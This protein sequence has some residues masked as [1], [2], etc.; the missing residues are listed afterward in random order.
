MGGLTELE[1]FLATG[2]P[3]PTPIWKD[4]DITTTGGLW[5]SST[6]T[7]LAVT[8]M[9]EP[10]VVNHTKRPLLCN[11]DLVGESTFDGSTPCLTSAT[12]QSRRSCLVEKGRD[13]FTGF[14]PTR[15]LRWDTQLRPVEPAAT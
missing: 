12:Y 10:S 4:W 13:D 14:R 7:R 5:M 8:T 2:R 11:E 6:A 3:I 9:A 15:E 1:P